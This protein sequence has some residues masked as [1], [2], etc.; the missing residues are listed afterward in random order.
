[1]KKPEEILVFLNCGPNYRLAI[2]NRTIAMDC[3]EDVLVAEDF[4][5]VEVNED[6]LYDRLL[7]EPEVK[8]QLRDTFQSLETDHPNDMETEPG[9]AYLNTGMLQRIIEEYLRKLT[10]C[11][12]VDSYLADLDK[13]NLDGRLNDAIASHTSESIH[14]DSVDYKDPSYRHV[15]TMKNGDEYAFIDTHFYDRK[16]FPY[17]LSDSSP[18]IDIARSDELL[19]WDEDGIPVRQMKEDEILA[20]LFTALYLGNTKNAPMPGKTSAN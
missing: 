14:I 11:A 8:E 15:I 16:I 12:P 20:L 3:I 1:M 13:D 10:G 18:R 9:Y 5:D 2:Q 19:Y 17:F 6:T 4:C 7:Q